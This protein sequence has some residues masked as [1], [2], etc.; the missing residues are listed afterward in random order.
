VVCTAPLFKG[1]PL[2]TINSH[3]SLFLLNLPGI[4]MSFR[5]HIRMFFAAYKAILTCLCALN[6]ANHEV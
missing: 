1:Y 5:L 6:D 2:S 4:H 3:K